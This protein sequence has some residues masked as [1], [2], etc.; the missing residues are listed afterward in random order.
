[1]DDLSVRLD[2]AGGAGY[3]GRSLL[4][5]GTKSAVY[6]SAVWLWQVEKQ[7]VELQ[8]EMDDLSVRLDE[9]GGATQAQIE[10]N[11]KRETE[12]QKLR[13]DLEEAHVQSDAQVAA[14]RKKQQDAVAE[15]AE[16]LEQLQ[17]LKQKSV[18]MYRPLHSARRLAKA[19][20]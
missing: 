13:R 1:M 20:E 9:A 2:E 17:K 16:Q 8:R 14:V 11:K 6:N 4:Y 10:V 5:L 7:R 18:Y 12:L 19:D 3:R 15:L